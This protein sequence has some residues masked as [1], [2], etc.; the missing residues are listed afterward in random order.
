MTQTNAD[1]TTWSP[2]LPESSSLRD[3]FQPVK[4]LVA[5][6]FGLGL[7]GLG[8]TLLLRDHPQL[9]NTAVWV[10]GSVVLATS[11][12]TYLF[13]ERASRGSKAAFNRVRIV[14]II[15]PLAIVVLILLPDPFPVWMKVQQGLCAVV[16]AA[17]AVLVNRRP[18]RRHF[19]R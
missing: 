6:Y 17:L 7:L 9:V 3:A 1:S 5:C 13:A 10:R 15:V 11:A 12:L 19:A 14:S 8:A 2:H 4:M 18:V 16:V